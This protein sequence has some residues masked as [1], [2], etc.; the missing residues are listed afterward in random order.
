MN[1]KQA[2]CLDPA[3]DRLMNLNIY[4]YIYIV[5]PLKYILYI[6]RQDV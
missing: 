6:R 1:N 3:C 5:I 2:V 4:K